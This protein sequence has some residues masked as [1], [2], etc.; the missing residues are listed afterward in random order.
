MSNAAAKDLI[1]CLAA[2]CVFASRGICKPLICSKTFQRK[3]PLVHWLF[4][5]TEAFP[6]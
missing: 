5:G 4:E 6:T 2:A 3:T 1:E